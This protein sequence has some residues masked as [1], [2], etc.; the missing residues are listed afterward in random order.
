MICG[1]WFT[2]KLRPGQNTVF[3]YGRLS[4]ISLTDISFDRQCDSNL[5]SSYYLARHGY[6]HLQ[7]KSGDF[8]FFLGKNFKLLLGHV[9]K[10]RLIR[11]MSNQ[12]LKGLP[13]LSYSEL[14]K[15]SFF[16]STCASMKDRRMSYR[17]LIGNKSTE[18]L[19]T[20]HMDST[21]RLRVNGLYGSFGYRYARAVAK[22]GPS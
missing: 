20:L 16:C 12:K 10:E 13:N 17:N 11:S 14:K 2:G 21:G 1:S 18:P 7:S 3:T 9:G 8:L 6:R 22:S 4:D 19:H 5:L 15:V